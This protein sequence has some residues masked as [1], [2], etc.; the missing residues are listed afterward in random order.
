MEIGMWG[1]LTA[2]GTCWRPP[3][4]SRK[5]ARTV[6]ALARSAGTL[7]SVARL[8]LAP[9]L[10]TESLAIC[11]PASGQLLRMDVVPSGS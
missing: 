2:R 7:L 3:C 6:S 9:G 8:V 10:V 11:S 5:P 4:L 1:F